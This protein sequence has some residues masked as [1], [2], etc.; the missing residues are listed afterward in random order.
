MDSGT[1]FVIGLG[2]AGLAHVDPVIAS[3]PKLSVAVIL[4]TVLGSQAPDADTLLRLR[5][6]AVYIRNHRGMSHSL[7]AIAIWTL[8]ITGALA[9]A[10]P[11][12]L[13]AKLCLWVG[14]AVVFH[15]FTD[16][17]N[18]YGTQAYRPFSEKWVSWN[19]IH[20]F[21]PVIF[22]MHILA[23]AVWA[24]P[25]GS[26][27]YIF[28]TLYV[29]IAAYY[30]W[31]TWVHYKLEKSLHLQDKNPAGRNDYTLIPTVN[32]QQ[33]NVVKT[34]PDGWYELGE[35]KQG[36]LTWLDK[37]NC[38]SHPAAKASIKHPDVAAFLYLSSYA[39]PEVKS[40]SWGYEVRWTDVRYRHRNKYP[41][42]AVLL[43]DQKYEVMDSYVG[44]L[45][46]EKLGKRLRM[47]T[48]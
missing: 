9:F 28:P 38:V 10:F 16:L 42:V 2:L 21:D 39:C 40:H 43:M 12:I 44:W 7:P 4:G 33:W 23:I 36:Q 18:T 41:F 31:R 27:L 37:V 35:L 15:V 29:L 19:I 5:G 45:S 1:H 46:D 26:P 6:N 32:L 34:M 47:D 48:Y 17:F 13:I 24:L 8:C 20:I 3:D 11:G 25:F 14:V 22:M 30:V